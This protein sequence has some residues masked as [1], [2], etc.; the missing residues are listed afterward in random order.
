MADV[1]DLLTA[2]R[3]HIQLAQSRACQLARDPLGCSGAPVVTAI[4][5]AWNNLATLID[6]H[7][8]AEDETCRIPEPGAPPADPALAIDA[9]ERDDGIRDAIRAAR[10]QPPGSPG[11][12][13]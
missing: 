7:M 13:S 12:G 2:S 9:A 4:C 10:L 6:W 11:G 1:T 5:S 8:A 3:Y